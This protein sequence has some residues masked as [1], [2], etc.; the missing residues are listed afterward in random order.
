MIKGIQAQFSDQVFF[1]H[2]FNAG[3]LLN[4]LLTTNKARNIF[5]TTNRNI[6][7]KIYKNIHITR[8]KAILCIKTENPTFI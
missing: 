7:I 3:Y 2:A 8:L 1:E 4:N 6:F 5:T